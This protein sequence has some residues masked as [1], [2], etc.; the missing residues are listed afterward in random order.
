M[1]PWGLRAGGSRKVDIREKVPRPKKSLVRGA[2][3][4]GRVREGAREEGA[5]AGSWPLALRAWG[6]G[7]GR[8]LGVRETEGELTIRPPGWCSGPAGRPL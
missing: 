3:G 8:G 7:V 6:V 2:A 4:G 1:G 5:Q